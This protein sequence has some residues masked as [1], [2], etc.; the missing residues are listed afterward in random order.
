MTPEEADPTIGR[1]SPSSPIGKSPPQ[2]RGGRHRR[3]ARALGDEGVRD[4]QARHDPRPGARTVAPAPRPEAAP[5][6][7]SPCTPVEPGAATSPR[8]LALAHRAGVGQILGPRRQQPDHR[9][10]PRTCAAGPPSHLGRAGPSAEGQAAAAPI[11][12]RSRRRW[13]SRTTTSPFHQRLRLRAADGRAT[14]RAAKRRDL[15]PPVVPPS[16]PARALPAALGA[17]RV[18][19]RAHA[20]SARSATARRPSRRGTR[21]TSSSPCAPATTS[22]SPTRS[23]L[24]ASAACSPRSGA[25]RR[26]ASARV[27]RRRLSRARGRR[28]RSCCRGP[29]RGRTP[30]QL[31]VAVVGARRRREARG[32][33]TETAELELYPVR[34]RGACSR[35]R[36][37]RPSRGGRT[38]APSGGP[39]LARRR[40]RRA[41]ARAGSPPGSTSP[42]GRASYLLVAAG[43]PAPRAAERACADPRRAA[44]TARW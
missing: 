2:P 35:R 11:S 13:R 29:A 28:R 22:S 32:R 6:R 26:R 42:A 14:C 21:S 19:G 17:R 40:R 5:P 3:G 41:T 39:A 12:R 38:S 7:V 31:R 25:A 16:R 30:A 36:W 24:S 23:W 10:R 1:I 8:A 18:G 27:E 37:S 4:R 43:E 34:G 44:C 15:K 33:R 20:C 9:P